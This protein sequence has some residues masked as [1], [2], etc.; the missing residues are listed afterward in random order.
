V[1]A[2]A[3]HKSREFMESPLMRSP[4]RF[5]EWRGSGKRFNAAGRY[6]ATEVY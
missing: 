6:P 3:A 5:D 1:A 2:K 4:C